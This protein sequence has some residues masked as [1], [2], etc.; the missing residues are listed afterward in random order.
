LQ[1]EE[2]KLGLRHRN[3]ATFYLWTLS[4]GLGWLP[5]LAAGAGGALLLRRDAVLA[6]VLLTTPLLLLLLLGS[7]ERYFGRW[8]LPAYPFL[9]LLGGYLAV[10]LVDA[11]A[12]G[13][14]RLAAIGLGIAGAALAGQGLVHSLHG[15]R[16]LA[17]ADT[18][19]LTRQWLAANLPAGSRIVLEPLTTSD[20]TLRHPQLPGRPR[21]ATQWARFAVSRVSARRTEGPVEIEDYGFLLY[22]ALLRDYR[23]A[24]AC[25]VVSG[26]TVSDRPRTTPGLAPEAVAYYDALAREGDLV[27]RATP[28]RPGKGPVAFDFDWSYDYYPL[29]YERPGPTMSVYRLRGGRCGRT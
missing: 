19:A 21:S 25:W 10:R 17:R 29:A 13:R 15:D 24:G 2:I 1:A 12:R 7:H 28:Y 16:V 9:C 26:S 8:L 4:W 6:A 27:Y 11:L 3:P 23:R 20:W 14:P 18:R 5:L 22:P